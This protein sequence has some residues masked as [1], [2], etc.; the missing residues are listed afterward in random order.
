[1]NL[2]WLES[3]VLLF[4]AMLAAYRLTR[5]WTV[6][7]LP[8]LP[9]VRAAI[10]HWAHQRWQPAV[11]LEYHRRGLY[12]QSPEEMA[13]DQRTVDLY[14]GEPPLTKLVTCPW[15]SGFWISA[16]VVLAASLLPAWL[17]WPLA[18]TLALSAV[19]GLI[20]ARDD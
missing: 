19:T 10:E 9:R 3:P 6:D 5:L 7:T 13:A 16:G 15:C 11:R 8:P 17:W 12:A 2:A 20:A 1:V 4:V 14:N 18:A